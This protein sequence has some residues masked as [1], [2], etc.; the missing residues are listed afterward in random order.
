VT[1]TSPGAE[2]NSVTVCYRSAILPQC[3][4]YQSDFPHK[5]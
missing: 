5:T 3:H 1:L 2:G 4:R